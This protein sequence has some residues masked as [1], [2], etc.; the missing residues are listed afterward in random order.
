MTPG[1]PP[2]PAV[3]P[4][5]QPNLAAAAAFAAPPPSLAPMMGNPAGEGGWGT[6]SRMRH[7]CHVPNRDGLGIKQQ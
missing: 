6:P 4:G 7:I 3:L 2:P 1:A 5:A